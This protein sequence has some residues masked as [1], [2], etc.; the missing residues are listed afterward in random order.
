M[1]PFKRNLY[2]PIHLDLQNEMI[3]LGGP[4][5]C[6]KTTLARQLIAQNWKNEQKRYLNWDI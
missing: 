5:Q 4:R 2:E 1:M 6:A 3:F